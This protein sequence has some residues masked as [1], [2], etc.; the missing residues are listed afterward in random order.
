MKFVL[1]V[2]LALAFPFAAS[3]V[4]TA[5]IKAQNLLTGK[6]YVV[7]WMERE[8]AKRAVV[9]VFDEHNCFAGKVVGPRDRILALISGTGA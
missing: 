8:D 4:L 2:L 5:E 7:F 1:A 9:A 3:A 6:S